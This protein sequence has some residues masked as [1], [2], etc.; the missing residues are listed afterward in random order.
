MNKE[1][2][3]YSALALSVKPGIYQHYKGGIY[4]VFGVARH[5]E[6]EGQELVVYQSV[7]TGDRW[8]RPLQQFLET[9]DSEN[10]HGPRFTFIRSADKII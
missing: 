8:V 4:N 2:P 1:I 10:Y 5:T 6:D 7:E 3:P 9:I